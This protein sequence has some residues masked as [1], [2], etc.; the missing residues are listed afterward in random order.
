MELPLAQGAAVA[1]E[2]FKR[3]GREVVCGGGGGGK[4]KGEDEINGDWIGDPA[5]T[6]ADQQQ[7]NKTKSQPIGRTK[8][9]MK[10]R[11]SSKKRKR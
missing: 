4:E 9:E 10:S 6:P 5:E 7:C 8:E 11:R 1:D 2:E 3:R